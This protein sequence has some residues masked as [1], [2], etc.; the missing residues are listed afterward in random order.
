M[1]YIVQSLVI[2]VE[3]ET[4]SVGLLLILRLLYTELAN[5]EWPELKECRISKT[6]KYILS[7]VEN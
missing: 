6:L 1:R 4:I 5:K 7:T 2:N 3:M